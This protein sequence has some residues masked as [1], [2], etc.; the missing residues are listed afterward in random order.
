MSRRFSDEP[1]KAKT[2]REHGVGGVV[3]P[4]WVNGKQFVLELDDCDGGESMA[5]IGKNSIRVSAL[6]PER[7]IAH[8]VALAVCEAWRKELATT[9]PTSLDGTDGD[10]GGQ[11]N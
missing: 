8:T 9:T 5:S 11:S 1:K 3:M 4:I 7:A 2:A 10:G 6:M